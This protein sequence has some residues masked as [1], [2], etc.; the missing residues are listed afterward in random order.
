MS[1]LRKRPLSRAHRLR[2]V[3]AKRGIATVPHHA[4]STRGAQSLAHDTSTLTAARFAARRH[5]GGGAS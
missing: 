2:I 1:R 5:N 4:P 3:R